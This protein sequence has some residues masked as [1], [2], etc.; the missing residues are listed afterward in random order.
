MELRNFRLIIS[1][2]AGLGGLALRFGNRV[3]V[4]QNR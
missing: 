2:A 1:V 4:S 3:P